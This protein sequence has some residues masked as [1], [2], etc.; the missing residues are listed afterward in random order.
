MAP[1]GKG[2]LGLAIAREIVAAHG[3]TLTATSD[4]E[5]GTE[6]TVVLPASLTKPAEGTAT[7]PLR[8]AAGPAPPVPAASLPATALVAPR[9]PRRHGRRPGAPPTAESGKLAALERARSPDSSG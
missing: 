3:G 5:K 9:S 6:F 7:A 1:S 8:P 2:G 4:P